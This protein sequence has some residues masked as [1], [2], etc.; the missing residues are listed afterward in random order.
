MTT[1]QIQLH[2]LAKL[3]EGA[4]QVFRRD[5]TKAL[6]VTGKAVD[7]AMARCA[8]VT[9]ITCNGGAHIRYRLAY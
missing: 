2:V 7:E 9:R 3:G 1:E 5:V 8:L 4:G 6:G